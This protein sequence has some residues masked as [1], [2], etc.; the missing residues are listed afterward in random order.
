[1][2]LISVVCRRPS[3]ADDQIDQFSE[4]LNTILHDLNLKNVSTY[5][6]GDF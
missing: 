3:H 4:H 5:I 6:F 2:L 1:M